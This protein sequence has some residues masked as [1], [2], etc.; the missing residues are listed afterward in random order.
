MLQGPKNSHS[1]CV[2]IIRLTDVYCM[3]STFHF[4]FSLCSWFIYRCSHHPLHTQV[5]SSLS[6]VLHTPPIVSQS[7]EITQHPLRSHAPHLSDDTASRA[8]LIGA[9]RKLWSLQKQKTAVHLSAHS[10]IATKFQVLSGLFLAQTV[11]GLLIM[12]QRT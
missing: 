7:T 8:V 11:L 5:W 1:N 2:K 12:T 4:S 10:I 9:S 3:Y 6:R